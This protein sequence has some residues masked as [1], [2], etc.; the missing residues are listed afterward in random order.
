MAGKQRVY[1]TITNI[2]GRDASG[3]SDL[4]IPLHRAKECL[5]V[6]FYNAPLGRKRQGWDSFSTTGANFTGTISTLMAFQ[7]GND[8]SLAEIW[9]VDDASP[10]VVARYASSAFSN[11]T[12]KD[13]I[14]ANPWDIN[15]AVMNGCLFMT[16]KSAQPRLHCWNQATVRRVG[17]P[18]P[19]AATVANTGGGAYA[20]T[21][22]TYKVA[23]IVD[24]GG[25]VVKRGE[26]SP[27][28]SFTPSGAG[29]AA[30]ITQ[31]AVANEGETS[32]EIYGA[33]SDGV[34]YGPI[35]TVAIATT[36]YDDSTAPSSYSTFSPA[37]YVGQNTAPVSWRF[38]LT[39]GNRLI[40][41]GDWDASGGSAAHNRVWFTPVQG[42][43]GASFLDIERV[44]DIFGIQQNY[45]DLT[46][47]N[48][49]YITGLAGPINGVIYVFKNKE[50]W[51]LIPT[52]IDTAP[53]KAVQL[54]RGSGIGATNQ[55]AIA[56]GEDEHGQPALYFMSQRGPYRISTTAGLQFLGRDVRDILVNTAATHV[57]CIVLWQPTL[58][59]MWFWVTTVTDNDP[60]LRFIF[61]VRLGAVEDDG[62]V[63][64][65]WAKHTGVSC[66]VRT[67][68]AVGNPVYGTYVYAGQST[69]T[70]TVLVYGI[71][72]GPAVSDNGT[73]Y[74]ASITLPARHYGGLEGNC[75]VAEPIAV[76]HSWSAAAVLTV[77]YT[78]N[79]GRETASTATQTLAATGSETALRRTF[80]GL[81]LD[82]VEAVT[83]AIGDASANSSAWGLSALV[84][85]TEVR[86]L[87]S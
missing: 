10:P 81:T 87:A 5:N 23:W 28:V 32:W 2:R 46:V 24:S 19:A 30:R 45:I 1:Q 52:G 48:G 33:A 63:R 18:A 68:M 42:T 17:F 71:T 6:D 15:T 51:K 76:I 64:N 11:P 29:T 77:T 12:L 49:T 59:Q 31:P 36:T 61:D 55:R 20:N 16:Y 13:A 79:Y 50:V 7:P 44:P 22:R 65:G 25:I 74:Q 35:A 83:V 69:A 57:P 82:D 84:I 62:S 4:D 41:A 80:E 47:N 56:M 39:D 60:T 78:P 40:G 9:G 14:T 21:P 38:I 27:A 54:A 26:L 53:Y 86:E 85:P 58:R 66:N 37:P 8:D 43:T 70:N 75:A 3:A 73:T 72:L 34:Y 67:A